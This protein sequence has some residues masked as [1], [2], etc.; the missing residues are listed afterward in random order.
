MTT[1]SPVIADAFRLLRADLRHDLDQAELLAVSWEWDEHDVGTA[2]ELI[3]ELVHIIQQLLLDHLVQTDGNCQVCLS[4]WPCPVVT[5]IH[6]FV[7]D[8]DR[9]LATLAHQAANSEQ[10]ND[11]G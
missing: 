9:Q 6:A 11:H 10:R 1:I 8:P 4:V 7:R 2:R 3:C 5:T